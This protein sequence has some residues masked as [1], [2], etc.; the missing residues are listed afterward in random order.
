MSQKNAS[1]N[2][3]AKKEEDSVSCMGSE[4]YVIDLSCIDDAATVISASSRTSRSSKTSK[5]P[6]APPRAPANSPAHS[7]FDAVSSISKV[8]KTS[9]ARSNAGNRVI[10]A[11]VL[12]DDVIS[13]YSAS[14]GRAPHWAAWVKR[15]EDLYEIP[16]GHPFINDMD[17]LYVG[18]GKYKGTCVGDVI[19]RKQYDQ[20]YATYKE[21]RAAKAVS[22]KAAKAAPEKALSEHSVSS[23][24]TVRRD[25]SNQPNQAVQA[26]SMQQS[27]V[28]LPVI[29]D[30][31]AKSVARSI[32][33]QRTVASMAKPIDVSEPRRCLSVR[34]HVP[35]IQ[36]QPTIQ[37][38]VQSVRSNATVRSSATVKSS[39]SSRSQA[40]RHSRSLVPATPHTVNTVIPYRPTCSVEPYYPPG[41]EKFR[42][43]NG[44]YDADHS[45][46]Y[47]NTADVM[48]A[49]VSE[50]NGYQMRLRGKDISYAYEDRS[51]C[52]FAVKITN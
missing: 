12:E 45:G 14:K 34:G 28:Q 49:G 43:S 48:F 2:N 32:R 24:R 27:A 19:E 13:T 35:A 16:A 40:S 25:Q 29:Q 42:N 7:Q 4:K 10:E 39:V 3:V 31:C 41:F 37:E 22:E 36:V 33:S 30:D 1:K 15:D 44:A 11:S 9:K 18:N 5:A 26:Q 17:F 50:G 38:D 8:S 47:A 6:K 20:F 46:K 52:K 23:Q 51:G 21:H